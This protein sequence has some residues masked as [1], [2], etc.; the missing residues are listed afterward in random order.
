MYSRD[1]TLSFLFS[2]CCHTSQSVR[3]LWPVS[4]GTA[5][6][7]STASEAAAAV[8]MT[9]ISWRK[10][11][12]PGWRSCGWTLASWAPEWKSSQVSTWTALNG[13]LHFTSNVKIHCKSTWGR[14]RASPP[15]LASLRTDHSRAGSQNQSLTAVK[16]RPRRIMSKTKTVL[17]CEDFL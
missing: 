14:S 2:F 17:F 10:T 8:P 6:A 11:P 1:L 13:C 12:S 4:S 15:S 5:T 9:C 3:D 16:L 7:P